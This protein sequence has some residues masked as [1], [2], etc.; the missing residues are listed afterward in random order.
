[1]VMQAFISINS[2]YF[3]K[4]SQ[5]LQMNKNN[6]YY[7]ETG[8]ATTGGAT[9]VGFPTINSIRKIKH[10]QIDAPDANAISVETLVEGQSTYV[11]QASLTAETAILDMSNVASL[12]LT[13]SGGSATYAVTAYESDNI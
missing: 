4:L 1:M 7:H 13:A 3:I 12:K 9:T 10:I 8:T 5:R 6:Y 2:I 11:T